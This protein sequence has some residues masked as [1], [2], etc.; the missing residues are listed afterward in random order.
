MSDKG[1]FHFGA[2]FIVQL[3]GTGKPLSEHPVT[4]LAQA[5]ELTDRMRRMAARH[6]FAYGDLCVEKA[7]MAILKAEPVLAFVRMLDLNVFHDQQIFTEYVKD[8]TIDR[9]DCIVAVLSPDSTF[10][11][12][13][14]HHTALLEP[15]TPIDPEAKA[16]SEEPGA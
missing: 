2:P 10:I 11:F 8:H 15:Y 3:P 16:P 6:T 4:P 9:I 1:G 13:S 7:G 5:M 12:F 14:L